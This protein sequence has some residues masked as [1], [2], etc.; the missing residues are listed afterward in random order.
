MLFDRAWSKIEENRKN[1]INCIP[2]GFPRF[3][4][5]L[6][7]IEQ[8][9][10]YI[11]TANSGVGKSQITDNMFLY[12]PYNFY[13]KSFRE[14]KI[15]LK[16]FYFSLEMDAESKV[17]QGMS[18]HLYSRYGIK[19]DVKQILSKTK[20]SLPEETYQALYK[21]KQYFD[22][23]E[24][25]VTII[26]DQLSPIEINRIVTNYALKNGKEVTYKAKDGKEYFSHYEPNNP[27]K[28]TI[29]ITDHLAELSLSRDPVTGK[30]L[31]IKA[32]IEQ[33]SDFNRINRNKYGFTFVDVQQQTASKED[34]EF[35]QGLSITT[36]LEPSLAGLGESKLTQRKANVVLGLF[37]PNRFELPSYRGY[38]IKLLNDNF[39]S[40]S[41]LKNRNG[42]SNVHV[43]LYFDG[44]VN[45][46][47]ELP[48][49]NEMA[50]S[51]YEY[52]TNK[53][54]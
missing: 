45:Y 8:K 10:Y 5:Y 50:S 33:H 35:Y 27:N 48:R 16:I 36:K 25:V 9:M 15:D 31:D 30:T 38:N 6:P 14:K 39:R 28:Y 34:Q 46:F 51:Q 18:K 24:S 3:E 29:F 1:E 43:G 47:Q 42:M 53:A 26:D 20:N 17:I 19:T 54:R 21:T 32:T 37:A 22:H 12:A 13:L 23:L 52:F 2:F 41:V 11:M 49:A 44:A 40:L 7:G 4:E